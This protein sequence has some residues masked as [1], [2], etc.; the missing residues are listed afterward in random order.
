[1]HGGND[2]QIR[3]PQFSWWLTAALKGGKKLEDFSIA[4]S[5]KKTTAKKTLEDP[6]KRRDNK[7]RRL[8]PEHTHS[9]GWA[10]GPSNASNGEISDILA[11]S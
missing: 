5:Q 3:R 1:M 6:P 4:P 11:V 7:L 8:G 9:P 10:D 2:V